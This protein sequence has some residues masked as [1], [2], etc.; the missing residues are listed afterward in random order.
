MAAAPDSS[1]TSLLATGDLV[2]RAQA[3]EAGARDLLFERYR[4]RLEAFLRARLPAGQ[5]GMLET[6]D[7]VQ[8]VSLEAFRGLGRFEYRGIG[9]FWAYLRSIAL[10]NVFDARRTDRRRPAPQPLSDESRFAPAL[11]QTS[12][13]ARIMRSEK[14]EAYERAL[15]TLRPDYRAALLLRL[16]L[17][18]G[19]DVI[20]SECRF[21]TL[22]VARMT[23]SRA[24][25]QVCQEMARGEEAGGREL[26]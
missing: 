23:V 2:G 14:L 20:A 4:S 24:L 11:D 5:R 15:A 25:K 22:A 17:G 3:G 13:L 1:G 10:H 12:P 6:Q 19:Y 21:S 18:L 8:E 16:E 26:P 7:L 9:S